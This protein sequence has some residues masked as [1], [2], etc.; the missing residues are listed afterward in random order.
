MDKETAIE[1]I[2]LDAMM[3]QTAWLIKKLGRLPELVDELNNLKKNKI[4]LH[5]DNSN[6]F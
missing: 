5:N 6:R 2:R 1:I 4:R 3:E